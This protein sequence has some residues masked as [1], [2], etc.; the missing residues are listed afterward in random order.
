MIASSLR[1][2]SARKTSDRTDSGVLSLSQVSYN[3]GV[4]AQQLH[5]CQRSALTRQIQVWAKTVGQFD[6]E[7]I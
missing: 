1:R 2:A 3:S 5:L 4:A 6:Y 7:H